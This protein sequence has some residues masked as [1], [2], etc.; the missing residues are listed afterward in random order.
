[1]QAGQQLNEPKF[2]YRASFRQRVIAGLV[3][4]V[5]VALL[6]L[7]WLA[8]TDRIDISWWSEPC[9][10]KQ[11][12]GLPCPTCGMTT[13]AFAFVRGKVFGSFYTQPAAAILCCVLVVVGFLAFLVA[14]FGI[15]FRFVR[16]FFAEIKV[17]HI[18]LA[19]IVVVAA[20]WA[21]TLARAIS[22]G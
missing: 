21:V 2:A 9:G 15:Y 12:Y 19:L 6:G 18:V 10:F 14:V 3:C 1:M 5:V 7:F 16:R 17:R 4:L 11:R 13:S 8:A 22:G 20:G